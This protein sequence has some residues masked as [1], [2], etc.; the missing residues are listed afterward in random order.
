MGSLD[1]SPFVLLSIVAERVTFLQNTQIVLRLPGIIAKQSL[2]LRLFVRVV[3]LGVFLGG[4]AK[5]LFEQFA[6][7][8]RVGYAHLIADFVDRLISFAQQ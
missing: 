6:E 8:K 1:G 7:I 2:L 3:D 4:E 5:G